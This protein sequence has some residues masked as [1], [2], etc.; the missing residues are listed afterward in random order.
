MIGGITVDRHQILKETADLFDRDCKGCKKWMEAANQKHHRQAQDYCE[1]KC[2]TG[3]RLLEL[4]DFLTYGNPTRVARDLIK[5]VYQEEQELGLLDKDIIKK[6]KISKKG[7]W[8]R[9]VFWGLVTDKNK[10]KLHLITKQHYLFLKSEKKQPDWFICGKLGIHIS[11]LKSYK[12]DWGVMNLYDVN[13]I[14]EGPN[15]EEISFDS[16]MYYKSQGW[17]DSRLV[18]HWQIS[19]TTMLRK[20]NAWR[21]CGYDVDKYTIQTGGTLADG[22]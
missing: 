19:R 16:Y 11:T 17:T 5:E 13:T 12:R 20:K 6:Y 7:L 15:G 10:S 9:K 21:L 18:V 4:G 3:K 2:S 22:N 8:K 14:T 1:T